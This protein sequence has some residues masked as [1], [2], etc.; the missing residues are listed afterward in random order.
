MVLGNYYDDWGRIDNDEDM[1]LT[2]EEC[3]YCSLAQDLENFMGIDLGHD[4]FADYGLSMNKDET[5][6]VSLNLVYE[7]ILDPQIE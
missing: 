1:E 2:D 7:V 6:N 5:M 4:D 3:E